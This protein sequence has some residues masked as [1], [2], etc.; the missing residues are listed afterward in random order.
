MV[1]KADSLETLALISIV[2]AVF[3]T[4]V[5]VGILHPH[6]TDTAIAIN[7][8]LSFATA[9]VAIMDIVMAY[10]TSPR[11]PS[12]NLLSRGVKCLL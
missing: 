9:M 11:F 12:S 2:V 3:I 4:I 6:G 10:G 5:G 1:E 7:D 8:K